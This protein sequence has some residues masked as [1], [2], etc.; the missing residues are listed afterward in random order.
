MS[1]HELPVELLHRIAAEC[2]VRDITALSSTCHSLRARCLDSAVFQERAQ[3]LVSCDLHG[4]RLWAF[5]T[6]R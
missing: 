3:H 6:E 5:G 2:S 4:R 1:L